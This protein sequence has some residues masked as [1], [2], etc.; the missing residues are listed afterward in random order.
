MESPPRE[1]SRL[2][3][4]CEEAGL[5]LFVG[6][7]SNSHHNVWGDKEVRPRGRALLAFLTLSRMQIVN[8][9]SVLTYFTSERQSV[10]D[11]TLCSEEL[12]SRIT[13]WEV[14]LE[15]SL[16]DHRHI[17]FDLDE[18]FQVNETGYRN[19]KATRWD[20]YAEELEGRLV[21]LPSRYESEADV[22]MMLNRLNNA[23]IVS[24]EASCPIK[25]RTSSGKTPWWNPHVKSHRKT[26]KK[27]FNKAKR[28]KILNHWEDF[29]SA[30]REY[31]K[32]HS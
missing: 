14:S 8:R 1:L 29:K 3:L 18:L 15:A 24:Y 22:E 23:I 17:L 6:C 4:Y 25:P 28:T 20:L 9:G 11:L 2:V 7:D 12:F 5:P 10:I 26:V 31:K 32:S 30:Q 21:G 13:S 16:S 19:S 27:L